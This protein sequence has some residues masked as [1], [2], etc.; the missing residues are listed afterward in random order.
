MKTQD[1]GQVN[2]T[3]GVK[4]KETE[5]RRPSIAKSCGGWVQRVER[6]G[7]L[8]FSGLRSVLFGVAAAGAAVA[9]AVTVVF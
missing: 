5:T 6:K 4:K 7:Q 1:E 2:G 3:R 9:A 8:L